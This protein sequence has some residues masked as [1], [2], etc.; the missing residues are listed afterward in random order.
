MRSLGTVAIVILGLAVMMTALGL[1]ANAFW[2]LQALSPEGTFDLG[3]AAVIFTGAGLLFAGG[4]WLVAKRHA[5]AARLFEE[6]DVAI[7]VDGRTLLRVGVIVIGVVWV[8]GSIPR[9]LSAF[10][11]S[12]TFFSAGNEYLY[13]TWMDILPNAL[14]GAVELGVGLLFVLR[15]EAVAGRLWTLGATSSQV[16][17][18]ESPVLECPVCGA[19]YDP[20]E[21]RDMDAARCVKCGSRLQL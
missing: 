10:T 13:V 3:S 12:L 21:Y 14:A 19:P 18:P 9:W 17:A 7:A 15:S 20:A 1:F 5:L 16:Q 6:T 11:M 8:F 2:I 4:Y